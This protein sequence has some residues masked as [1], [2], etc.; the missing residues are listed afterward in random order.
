VEKNN[1]YRLAL[2]SK[3]THFSYDLKTYKVQ[4][5][6]ILKEV[7]V[8]NDFVVINI[9][10]LVT[11]NIPQLNGTKIGWINKKNIDQK[12]VF[13]SPFKTGLKIKNIINDEDLDLMVNNEIYD[14]DD[15]SE[16]RVNK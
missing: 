6:D 8:G 2:Q 7:E 5:Q 4:I 11:Y 15:D 16:I 12:M 3:P 13:E 10:N 14:Y 1:S 9:F